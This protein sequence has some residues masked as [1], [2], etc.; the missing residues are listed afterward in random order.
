M[1]S[2]TLRRLL[3]LCRGSLPSLPDKLSDKKTPRSES[4]WRI[5][6]SI[7]WLP[8]ERRRI[9]SGKMSLTPPNSS[10]P[11]AKNSVSLVLY[12]LVYNTK[13]LHAINSA[14]LVR[15]KCEVST[16]FSVLTRGFYGQFK[17]FLRPP[18]QDVF[19]MLYSTKIKKNHFLFAYIKISL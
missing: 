15:R 1:S 11:H 12:T 13:R 19:C 5:R 2:S 3:L 18:F 14:L 16:S 4:G 6:I 10:S 17:Y 9:S 7:P 8:S